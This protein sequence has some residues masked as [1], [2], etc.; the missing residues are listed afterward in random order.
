[1]GYPEI[2]ACGHTPHAMKQYSGPPII[3]Q[4]SCT[5][6]R[7]GHVDGCII[8]FFRGLEHDLSV[9]KTQK[10]EDC[11]HLFGVFRLR[12]VVE[13]GLSG[14]VRADRHPSDRA[15]RAAEICNVARIF[16]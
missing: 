2:A 3:A 9:D 15:Y 10:L 13:F 12:R 6:A 4:A 8:L 7:K 11:L 5:T 16:S 14:C 1:M